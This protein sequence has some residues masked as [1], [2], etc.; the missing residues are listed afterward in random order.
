MRDMV[1]ARR[2]LESAVAALT[3]HIKSA[4]GAAR[5]IAAQLSDMDANEARRFAAKARREAE[6]ASRE[7]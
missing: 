6:V 1:P 5:H 2:T 4:E 3:S 7:A